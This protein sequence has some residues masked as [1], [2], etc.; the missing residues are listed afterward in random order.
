MFKNNILPRGPVRV[1]G[2]FHLY[3]TT[4]EWP[5]RIQYVTCR[6]KGR[7]TRDLPRLGRPVSEP[8]KTIQASLLCVVGRLERGKKKARVGRWEGEREEARP[9]GSRISRDDRPPY[10]CYFSIFATFSTGVSSGSLFGGERIRAVNDAIF[11]KISVKIFR[12]V[13]LVFFFAPKAGMGD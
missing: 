6:I 9:R 1:M 2:S 12:P 4:K 5:S 11:K 7:G 13:V 8:F 3:L 10:D